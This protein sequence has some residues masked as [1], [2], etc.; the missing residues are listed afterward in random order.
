MYTN[1]QELLHSDISCRRYQAV[2]VGKGILYSLNPRFSLFVV[3]SIVFTTNADAF[4]TI[5]TT[6]STIEISIRE[7]FI[8]WCIAKVTKVAIAFLRIFNRFNSLIFFQNYFLKCGMLQNRIL[9]TFL[10]QFSVTIVSLHWQT[11]S[12]QHSVS[13]Y[14]LRR[15]E[16]ILRF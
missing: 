13:T 12:G 14:S 5:A 4:I 2:L 1:R 3:Y 10:G 11:I 16:T 15:F 6:A 7:Q 9:K 8:I